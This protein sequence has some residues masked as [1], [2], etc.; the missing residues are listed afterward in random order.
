MPSV[1]LHGDLHCEN[2]LWGGGWKAIDPKPAS[3][4]AEWDYVLLLRNR[5]SEYDQSDLV[6]DIR[7]R[8]DRLTDLA[9]GNRREAYLF[10]QFR[11]LLVGMFVSSL[12]V[13]VASRFPNPGT[14]PSW[15]P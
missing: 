9:G 4:P 10:A 5:F 7:R 11:A 12:A 13:V 2:I 15:M 6:R 8:L 14:G 3:G 1:L